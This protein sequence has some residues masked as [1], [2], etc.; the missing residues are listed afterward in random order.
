MFVMKI[1]LLKLLLLAVLGCGLLLPAA[2]AANYNW[3][4]GNSGAWG[5]PANWGP[6]GPVGPPPLATDTAI[7]MQ[8]P[9]AYW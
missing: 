4:S 5:L 8:A 7:A 1:H 3:V 2:R 9:T 6:P